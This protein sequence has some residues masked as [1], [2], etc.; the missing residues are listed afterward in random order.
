MLLGVRVCTAAAAAAWLGREVLV[1]SRGAVGAA[2]RG[3]RCWHLEE[4]PTLRPLEK[5]L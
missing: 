3:A 4:A 2:G 5:P 1:R